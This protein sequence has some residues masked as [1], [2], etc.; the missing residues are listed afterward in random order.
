MH[1]YIHDGPTPPGPN[2]Q[3]VRGV[4]FGLIRDVPFSFLYTNQE[5][6]KFVK[7]G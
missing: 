4:R 3:Q 5:I 1:M 2:L 7:Y 6:K